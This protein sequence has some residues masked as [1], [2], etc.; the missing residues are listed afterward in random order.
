MIF[1]IMVALLF[2]PKF[3]YLVLMLYFLFSSDLCLVRFCVCYILLLCRCSPLIFNAFPSVLACNLDLF[4]LFYRYMSFE[5]RYTTVAFI[6][7]INF[8]FSI[9]TYSKNFICPIERTVG[10]FDVDVLKVHPL[11]I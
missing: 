6:Y 4:F 11:N 5:Q 8:I 2:Y 1:I 10:Q 3:M 9:S 7:W